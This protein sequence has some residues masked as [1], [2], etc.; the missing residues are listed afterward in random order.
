MQTPRE[1]QAYLN[2]T[3]ITLEHLQI[4]NQG[5]FVPLKGSTGPTNLCMYTGSMDGDSTGTLVLSEGVLF[6]L[7]T[8][9]C[10]SCLYGQM[11]SADLNTNLI[12]QSG[13]YLKV[14]EKV[15]VN[16]NVRVDVCGTIDGLQEGLLGLYHGARFRADYPANSGRYDSV[17]SALVI[18]QLDIFKDSF[19]E[20]SEV[21]PKST[22]LKPTLH[23]DRLNLHY[24]GT[25][26]EDAF[27][28]SNTTT[29]DTYV[30]G[31]LN[32]TQCPKSGDLVLIANEECTLP[33]GEYTYNTIVVKGGATLRLEGDQNFTEVT[34]IS[35]SI[36]TDNLIVEAGGII[37]SV[38]EGR[39]PEIGGTPCGGG[40]E[41]NQSLGSIQ[42]PAFYGMGG[43]Y[44]RGG[45]QLDLEVTVEM[46]VDGIID[47][48]GQSGHDSYQN[49]SAGSGGSI[50]ITTPSLSGFGS[51]RAE[52]GDA[53]SG[54][55][56]SGG[57]IAVYSNSEMSFLGGLSVASGTST[58]PGKGG[59]IFMMDYSTG[60]NKVVIRGGRG[61]AT[62]LGGN[63][64]VGL[65]EI[66]EL[67]VEGSGYLQL[68][69]SLQVKLLR[70]DKTGF[71]KI[72]R[73]SRLEILGSEIAG[74]GTSFSVDYG[75]ELVLADDIL[76]TGPNPVLQLSGSL[77]TSHLIVGKGGETNILWNA[78]VNTDSVTLK[79]GSVLNVRHGSTIGN[80]A[81]VGN[82]TL[83]EFEVGASAEVIFGSM[84][85]DITTD[86]LV[87][88]GQARMSCSG[89]LQRIYIHGNVIIL[90]GGSEISV[91]SGGHNGEGAGGCKD[92]TSGGS[93]G[94]Q[95]GHS[96][97]LEEGKTYG[98]PHVPLNPGSGCS[99]TEEETRGGGHITVVAEVSL[100]LDGILTARG[101]DSPG[102][103]GA[104]SGGS[105][106]AKSPKI[107][108]LGYLVVTGGDAISVGGG[109]GGRIAV[110][111]PDVSEFHGV[112]DA[113]GGDGLYPG[114]AGT[115]ATV[116]RSRGIECDLLVDN[117]GKSSKS[118]SV[119]SFFHSDIH[120]GKVTILGSGRLTFETPPDTTMSLSSLEGDL[121][122]LL[123]IQSHQKISVA[124]TFSTN[125]LYPLRCAIK[126]EDGG[127]LILPPKVYLL[128]IP[129]MVSLDLSGSL[130]GVRTLEVGLSASFHAESSARTAARGSNN[131]LLF[132]DPAGTLGMDSLVVHGSGVMSLASDLN[133]PMLLLI[134]EELVIHYSGTIQSRWLQ[135]RSRAMYLEYGG[136]VNVVGRGWPGMEGPGSGKAG[137][138]GWTGASYGGVGGGILDGD[139]NLNIY[140]SIYKAD[141]FGSGGGG[142]SPS[143]TGS[144]GGLVEIEASL[145]RLD[146]RLD[147]SGTAGDRVM[148]GGS[149]GSV[150]ISCKSEFIGAGV[151]SVIGGDG[152][153]ESGGG[154][155]GGRIAV[156][157]DIV[158]AFAGD[159][160]VRGGN[161][162]L[163]TQGGGS[164]TA[165]WQ[166]T[167][168][169]VVSSAL[170]IDNRGGTLS[171]PQVTQI[172][173]TLSELNFNKLH[174]HGPSHL[175]FSGDLEVHVSELVSGSGSIISIHDG[176]VLSVNEE[177]AEHIFYCS[178][179]LSPDGELRLPPRATFNGDTN[180]FSG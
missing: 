67:V 97:E 46:R 7:S 35:M 59:V 151:I 68:E 175:K 65:S 134:L 37:T 124:R 167:V 157:L 91:D 116:D 56:G 146:G 18:Q 87:L 163:E 178:F 39:L 80:V 179:L 168:N 4:K 89:I 23:S 53:P 19:V 58:N 43:D 30:S 105:I 127:E 148:G 90:E 57:R 22:V 145:M 47:F 1:T 121:S 2:G 132:M 166:E 108:G 25:F 21:C 153:P 128:H 51:I 10:P 172:N 34:G 71:I 54:C 73:S 50:T 66:D 125:A 141:Q 8:C 62:V 142:D 41:E 136:L 119:L 13:G 72:S 6:H 93:H 12:V 111:S 83:K 82:I 102:V 76:L 164:G 154:G 133:H 49:S 159:L 138:V 28:L 69:R 169:G 113:A 20:R 100:I 137:S 94:G 101:Q 9:G 110:E 161:G 104:G 29:I 3:T 98:A 114:A 144:G 40:E 149:G 103:V 11:P 60:K 126:V 26:E 78:V 115:V 24:G 44:V 88:R 79:E 156:Y 61:I 32:T 55:G 77:S 160:L 150:N 31:R 117:K 16:G 42:N 152:G 95:G 99:S 171:R 70:G 120:Y 135:I 129:N 131:E 165:Y 139:P 123:F 15:T 86:I 96:E 173:E 130:T 147:A 17:T 81:A 170:Y 63:D 33:V 92:V 109:G 143:E 177:F 176:M 158:G 38:G 14:P 107:S 85:T 122:G 52:G 74:T 180:T 5:R 27:I 75:S 36:R 45:G 162:G 106:F 155:S 118:Y 140:G 174:L 84:K 112:F 48:S 64:L